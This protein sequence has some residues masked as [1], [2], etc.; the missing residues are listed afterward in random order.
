MPP[1]FRTRR[2][3]LMGLSLWMV[4]AAL[5]E[6]IVFR[7]TSLNAWQLALWLTPP[8]IVEFFVI[9]ANWYIC[10]ISP[11]QRGQYTRVF[12]LQALA[13]SV[14]AI[15]FL[16]I[17]H[18]YAWFLNHLSDSPLWSMEAAK[19]SI[20]LVVI[21]FVLYIVI[22]LFHYLVIS[23]EDRILIEQ[24]LLEE[25]L[26]TVQAEFRALRN[27]I[28]PH[29]LFNTLTALSALGKEDFPRARETLLNLA[30]FLRYS[31]R[32]QQESNVTLQE[33]IDHAGN[34][35]SV[36]KMRLGKRL[37][38]SFQVD[39]ELTTMPVMSLTLLP[40]VENAV[41]HG[42]QSRL[43]GGTI[44]ITAQ[45]SGDGMRITVNNP[46]TPPDTPR[47]AGEG[48][49]LRTLERRLSIYYQ[50]KAHLQINTGS[51]RF[52]VSVSIP[53][54]QKQDRTIQG[55]VHE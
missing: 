26:A 25:K 27:T 2:Y 33:E 51:D 38:F 13:A 3:L 49:G 30:D 32:F 12:L 9:T 55:G 47:P 24:R 35:L 4:L 54:D 29:F 46:P 48:L 40:L 41:K 31:L 17:L 43:E 10:R 42:I 36:E 39:E 15:L 16:G 7:L 45:A 22:A 21:G 6:S 37:E 1:L 8:I 53:I 5:L 20:L 50:G 28:H 19:V 14:N 23:L 52:T 18:G 11:L 44:H 34:Y